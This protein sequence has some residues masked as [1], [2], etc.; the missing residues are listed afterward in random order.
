MAFRASHEDEQLSHRGRVGA[1]A[2]RLRLRGMWRAA[3]LPAE[4]PAA[5]VRMRRLRPPALGDRRARS[6]SSH[7]DAVAQMVFGGLLAG[8][9]Q[10]RR[11][12]CFSPGAE[13]RYATAWRSALSCARVG[14]TVRGG[15]RRADR[16][17]R[18]LLRRPW[19][20][21]KP[22]SQSGRPK[23]ELA[24]D[25]PW[26]RFRREAARQR[27]QAERLRRPAAPVSTIL[28]GG[29]SQRAGAFGGRLGRA[30]RAGDYRRLRRLVDLG[31]DFRHYSVR[32]GRGEERRDHPAGDPTCCSANSKAWLNGTFHGVS[33]KHL[34]RRRCRPATAP[35]PAPVQPPRPDRSRAGQ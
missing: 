10:A 27:H 7:Q 12:R 1:L 28:P 35:T 32:S 24:G 34:P 31:Q 16:S 8:P 9:R 19:Q 26:R 18:E 6:V 22:R 20:T 29:D 15:A 4:R 23:Q 5:G 33:A 2:G 14:R 21:G 17:R 13:L 25:R 3:R 11:R 30:G